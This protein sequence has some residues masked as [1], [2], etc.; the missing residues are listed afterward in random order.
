MT[1]VTHNRPTGNG[2]TLEAAREYHQA[3][4]SIIPIKPDG[5]KAPAVKWHLYQSQPAT[6][7]EIE[8]WFAPGHYGI[9]LVCGRVSGGREVI[10]FDQPNLFEPWRDRVEACCRGLVGRLP[11]VRTPRPGLQ[12]HY[13]C[14]AVEGNQKLAEKPVTDPE[15][16]KPDRE[17]LIETRG[18][19]GYVLMPGS[20]AACH[21]TGRLYEQ[22][23]G[24]PLTEAPAISPEERQALL[25]AARAFNVLVDYPGNA[26]EAGDRFRGRAGG[27][28]R[29]G[30]DF[31]RRG[32]DWQE[33]L[34]GWQVVRKHGDVRY[35]RRPRKDGPGWSATTGYC[36]SKAGLD[37]LAVFSTN[38]HPFE[39]P[40]GKQCG[41]YSKFTAYAVV[42]HNGDFGAAAKA[43]AAQGYGHRPHAG[44]GQAAEPRAEAGG[45]PPGGR[46]FDVILQHYR[47]TYQPTFR[48]GTAIISATLGR[49]VKAAEATYGA[50]RELLD[51][52]RG[53]ADVPRQSDGTPRGDKLPAFHRDWARSA[54]A[55][56]LKT[57]PDEDE[58]D[59]VSE[60]AQEEFR[61]KVRTALLT[62][63]TLGEVVIADDGSATQTQRRSLIGW[64]Q[65]FAAAKWADIRCHRVWTRR[66]VRGLEVA[67]RTELFGQIGR[68]ELVKGLTANRFG[69]LC[70]MYGVGTT[71]QPDGTPVKVCGVRAVLLSPEFLADL[72]PQPDGPHPGSS[73][74]PVDDMADSRSHARTREKNG[75]TATG[76]T[77]A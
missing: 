28:L 8:R 21:K 63:V 60:S 76:G 42:H 32:P 57:L 53:A 74:P 38:A 72:L 55:E 56:L 13:A 51:K 31:N 3:G 65:L 26:E 35:W 44:N 25:D 10:D 22:I 66:G 46:G 75:K 33:I 2:P 17:T 36:R 50:D 34:K 54:W 48:R 23:A 37:L 73:P 67:L 7:A 68:G 41:C 77:N 29:P 61:V 69:R 40:Q 52:L 15:A 39:V 30:D 47:D 9:A 12:L 64:C 1:T 58:A 11:L 14:E 62:L 71:K 19:G 18:E 43:L 6:A 16:G 70:E 27:P 59:E 20:P 4:L 49:E 5:T 24:P 45:S